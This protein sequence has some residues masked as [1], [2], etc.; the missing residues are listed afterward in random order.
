[1][2][3]AWIKSLLQSEQKKKDIQE[4]LDIGTCGLHIIHDALKTGT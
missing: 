4:L 2:V 3:L 1:M